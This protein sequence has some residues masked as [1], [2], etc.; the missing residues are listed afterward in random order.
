MPWPDWFSS[1]MNAK[2]LIHP[3]VSFEQRHQALATQAAEEEK[4]PCC[5]GV[6]PGFIRIILRAIQA[7]NVLLAFGQESIGF[8][9]SHVIDPFS[10]WGMPFVGPMANPG[11]SGYIGEVGAPKTSCCESTQEALTLWLWLHIA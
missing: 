1:K 2:R 6:P 3:E 5:K 9:H 4:W 8:G 11:S 7:R 10:C